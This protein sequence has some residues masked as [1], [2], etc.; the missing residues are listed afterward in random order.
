MKKMSDVVGDEHGV[1]RP[2]KLQRLEEE[3]EN[4]GR[5]TNSSIQ[6]VPVFDASKKFSGEVFLSAFSRCQ[7][8]LVKNVSRF[9]GNYGNNV[10]ADDSTAEE[11][12]HSNSKK[13]TIVTWK[14]L[15]NVYHSLNMRDQQSWCVETANSMNKSC[16]DG[17]EM[18]SGNHDDE[19]KKEIN[20]TAQSESSIAPH[21][22]LKPDIDRSK[23][24]VW[25]AYCSFL[26][27]HDKVQLSSLLKRLPLS[28]L[29]WISN[30]RYEPCIWI[31]FGRNHFQPTSGSCLE[32]TSDESSQEKQEKDTNED[33]L[34]GRPEHTDSISHDGTWH[35]QLSGMKRWLLRPTGKLLDHMSNNR[36]SKLDRDRNSLDG[37]RD[38]EDI[39][40]SG[41]D[42]STKFQVDCEEGDVIV[43]N[44]RLWYHQTVI[45][46]QMDPSVSYAI[47]FWTKC[48]NEASAPAE[49]TNVDGL[50]ATNDIEEGTIL[51][52]EDT[53]P[54]CELHR[55]RTN[56]NCEVVELEDGTN[57]VVSICPITAG[58]F[59]CVL[60]SSEDEDG[61]EKE[62]CDDDESG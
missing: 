8:V 17:Y 15:A 51:F 58:D 5:E 19:N 47:D 45:P 3:E 32:S 12:T 21:E 57:A 29:S 36:K 55:S 27:Q 22:F 30:W 28:E 34:Q 62:S 20:R 7:V 23:S 14:D 46:P 59:F 2:R 16:S 24:D 49:M 53:M 26:V 6:N 31:F 50:Y 10:N 60:E 41:W 33:C 38:H 54:D 56:P 42:E 11:D 13:R 52:T 9:G 18:P 48:D 40:Y 25:K 39:D 4:H 35:Y 44:T 1:W 37:D 61:E 43:I